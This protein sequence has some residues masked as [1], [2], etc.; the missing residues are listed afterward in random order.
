MIAATVEKMR[1]YGCAGTANYG[2][3]VSLE[4]GVL[5]GVSR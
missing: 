5:G 4:N 1:E 3:P 2:T